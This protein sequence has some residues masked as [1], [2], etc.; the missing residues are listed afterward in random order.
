MQ[1]TS[2]DVIVIALYF[3]FIAGGL[4]YRNM[5]RRGWKELQ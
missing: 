5:E 3:G 4:I 2:I 1:L